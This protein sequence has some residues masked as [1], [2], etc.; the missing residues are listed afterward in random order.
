MKRFLNGGGGLLNP[1]SL[2]NYCDKND[3]YMNIYIFSVVYL[4]YGVVVHRVAL[5]VLFS[6]IAFVRRGGVDFPK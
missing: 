1:H 4:G 5:N 3:I 2:E 6:E